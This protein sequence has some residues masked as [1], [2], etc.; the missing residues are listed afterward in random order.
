M[1][2]QNFKSDHCFAVG[3]YE[4]KKLKRRQSSFCLLFLVSLEIGTQLSCQYEG[5]DT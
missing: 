1:F 4:K 2:P 3:E 5:S